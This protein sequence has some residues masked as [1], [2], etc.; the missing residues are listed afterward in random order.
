MARGHQPRHRSWRKYVSMCQVVAVGTVF[1]CIGCSVG[2][3]GTLLARYTYTDT[4]VVLDSYTIGLQLRPQGPDGGLSLGYRRASYVFP[5]AAEQPEPTT[6]V[7]RCF[8]APWPPGSLVTRGITTLGME[9]QA[10][11]DMSRITL[12]YLDQ[13]LTA[14]PPPGASQVVSVFYNRNQPHRTHIFIRTE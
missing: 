12:G 7:W 6:V 1:A 14:G 11:P 8:A 9:I 13:M 5:R 10:T 3:Y 4:A 2:N